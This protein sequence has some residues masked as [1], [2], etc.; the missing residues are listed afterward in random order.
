MGKT[1]PAIFIKNYDSYNLTKDR[2]RYL[3]NKG[4]IGKVVGVIG[5]YVVRY[6]KGKRII[7]KRPVCFH[8]SMTQA[9]VTGRNKFAAKVKFARFLISDPIIKEIWKAADIEGRN[10]WNRLLKHNKITG[11]HPTIKNIITPP[12]HYFEIDRIYSLGSD[13]SIKSVESISLNEDDRIYVVIVP[14]NPINKKDAPFE[15]ISAGGFEG[16]IKLTNDQKLICSKYKNYVCFSAAIHI[17]GKN[18]EWSNTTAYEGAFEDQL[19]EKVQDFEHDIFYL[20]SFEPNLLNE[21]DNIHR[22]IKRNTFYF[23]RV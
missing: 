11:S 17:N 20:L 12:G 4:E 14:F 22:R 16:E 23:L 8:M 15:I 21:N 1:N 18:F 2:V 6:N 3:L 13:Y 19:K 5:P 7:S 10:A 9:A